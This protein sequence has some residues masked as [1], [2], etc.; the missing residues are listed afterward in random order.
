MGGFTSPLRLFSENPEEVLK[1]LRDG[2]I[3]YLGGATDQF[4][5]L[6]TLYALRSGLIDACAA[7]GTSSP[8]PIGS[9]A[10]SN[11]VPNSEVTPRS[12]PRNTPPIRLPVPSMRLS[13]ISMSSP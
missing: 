2:Y 12:K 1:R 11:A 6:H 3:E 5:D 13:R 7:D 4:T 9:W 10:P 8:S